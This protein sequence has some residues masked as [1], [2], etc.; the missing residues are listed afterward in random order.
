[1]ALRQTDSRSQKRGQQM[2]EQNTKYLEVL[3][4]PSRAT[5][6]GMPE[7]DSLMFPRIAAS[8]VDKGYM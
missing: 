6:V 3:C 2:T 5:T 8:T 7:M 4:R 1:M